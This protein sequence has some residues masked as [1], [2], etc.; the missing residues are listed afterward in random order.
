MLF[1]KALNIQTSS[2]LFRLPAEIRII[3]LRSPLLSSRPLGAD[4]NNYPSAATSSESLQLSSQLLRVC[5]RLYKEGD[6]LVYECNTLMLGFTIYGDHHLFH[7]LHW[8]LHVQDPEYHDGLYDDVYRKLSMLQYAPKAEYYGEDDTG[9]DHAEKIV[10]NYNI[11]KRF[12]K[13]SLYLEHQN[14]SHIN[15]PC[16]LVSELL[17]GKDLTIRTIQIG[18]GNER[19]E[20]DINE[21]G[22]Q[23]IES[24]RCL[25]SKSVNFT[26]AKYDVTHLTSII[27]SNL[28][29][30]DTFTKWREWDERIFD[31]LA[32][33]LTRFH[34]RHRYEFLEMS[35][36]S[37]RYDSDAFEAK[38]CEL[39]QHLIEYIEAVLLRC[40]LE[41]EA[42]A[43][44]HIA[45][46]TALYDVEGLEKL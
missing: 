19:R 12:K 28:P 44:S 27:E 38:K 36:I 34:N 40:E 2:G 9:D 21:E 3:I 33:D 8:D 37:M 20:M 6:P 5:Q 16:H 39:L 46:L 42:S 17:E 15:I 10:E 1:T 31:P 35:E 4:A 7:V 11:F 43:E 29:F 26:N 24:L 13:V 23:H 30:T 32:I 22:L 45:R 25:R 18:A 14:Q 41:C